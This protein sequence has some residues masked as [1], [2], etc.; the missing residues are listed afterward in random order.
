MNPRISIVIPV[1]NAGKYLEECLDSIFM[2]NFQEFELICVDDGS[3]DKSLSVLHD[4]AE[5]HKNMKVISQENAGIGNATNCAI[6]YATGEYLY[7]LDNDDTLV[8]DTVFRTLYDTAKKNNLDI[9]T[10]NYKTE[11]QVK[12]LKQQ[13]DVLMSGKQYLLNEFIPPLWSRFCKIEYIKKIDFKFLEDIPFVDTE[14]VPRI[15]LRAERVMHIDKVLYN[16]R[17]IGNETV[18]ISQNLNNIKSAYAYF[19]TMNTYDRLKNQ[20]DNLE[21]KN[22]LNKERFKATIETIRII[23]VVNIKE[24]DIIMNKM[25]QFNFS[26]FEK[27]MMNNEYKFFY[28]T[29]VL[30]SKKIYHPLIYLVRKITKQF[31]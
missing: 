18:S 21:V 3:T 28:N 6:K 31:I 24:S 5:N 27:L 13:S 22:M 1:Y 23:A 7:S 20:E 19:E 9:L 30:K 17:R 12:Y 2:Q 11:K 10:F 25:L 14:S 16:W 26:V 8:D 29:Y 4:Y 15:F